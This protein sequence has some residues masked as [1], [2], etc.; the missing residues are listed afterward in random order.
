MSLD[1][2]SMWD[3]FRGEVESQMRVFTDG[4]LALESGGAQKEPLAAA[5]R[6]AH[7]IKGA[8]RIVQ[9]DAAVTLAH[10]MEDCLV[11]A[12]EGVLTLDPAAID[13]LLGSG[14]LLS[15]LSAVEE[16]SVPAW[17]EAHGADVQRLLGLLADVRAGRAL[18][19]H[20]PPQEALP[21][22]PPPS[23]EDAAIKAP[24]AAAIQVTPT[25]PTSPPGPP[26]PPGPLGP[27][28]PARAARSGD[29]ADRSLKVTAQT[30]N[31]L[32]SLAGESL[33]HSRWL[34]PF[35][36]SLLGS[37]KRHSEISELLESLQ[38][39]VGSASPEALAT[40]AAAQQKV[41]QTRQ[42][43]ADRQAALDG[44]ALRAEGLSDRLYREVVASRMRPFGDGVEGFP[45]LV[46]DVARQ[47]G[48]QVQL[49]IVGRD[50]RVDREIL[51]R[52]EAPLNH[53]IRNS[54]DHGIEPPEV[55]VAAGKPP[56]GTI[57]LEA[58]HRAGVFVV[59][60]SDDGRG[61]DPER[62]RAKI[63]SNGLATPEMAANFSE[64]ELLE[65]LFL[66]GFSTAA[67][68]TEISGRGVGLDAVQEMAKSVGGVARIASR[69]GQGLSVQLELPLTLSVLR[70]FV[71]DISG[72]P[73]AFP[74]TRIARAVKV[75]RADLTSLEGQQYFSLD[76]EHVGV[77][78]ARE[79]LD[80]PGQADW[81][82]EI[83]VVLLGDRSA[84]YGLAVD[85]FLGEY[86][87][88]VRP[89]DPRL[90]KVA[91]I[92][93]AALMEDGS[94][95]LIVDVEDMTRSVETLLKGGRLRGLGRADAKQV[96]RKRIL[97]VEDSITVRELERALL[98]KPRLRCRGG[99]RWRSTGGTRFAPATTTSSSAT[100]TC[101]G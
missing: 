92:S 3:L 66:P 42:W 25:P 87:M 68:V 90:G 8:A 15:R 38:S 57:R 88:V 5:M 101:P 53:A 85:R 62:L 94:P 76:G 81:G 4:L 75:K 52:L 34:E 60:V 56:A 82:A 21:A 20:G 83:P 97:V 93:A 58:R 89:L 64:S 12:Q 67:A 70:T 100:S 44:F 29:G 1:A 78:S 16:S 47:L 40:L 7:S 95:V 54:L 45:R 71:A 33:V 98:Q 74:V 72:E 65:F 37:K 99:G 27:A 43:A 79:V 24:E 14:D 30:L 91:D 32:M 19:R 48:K 63:V 35:A 46:R 6:A 61:A 11:A 26:G 96:R 39:L 50:T 31:R 51:E 55:R 77:V 22:T 23:S 18:P 86:D 41:E 2:F 17:V 10:A 49:D 59:T 13:L 84:R 73:F 69:A 9:L 36:E 28:P 80:L